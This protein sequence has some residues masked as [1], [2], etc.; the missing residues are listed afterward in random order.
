MQ[1][2][3]SMKG[4]AMLEETMRLRPLLAFDFDGTLAPIVPRPADAHVSVALARRLEQLSRLLPVAVIT[5][6]GVDDV[7]PRLGFEPQFIIGNHGAEDEALT[8]PGGDDALAALR[9]RLRAHDASLRAAGVVVE[10]KRYSVALHYRLA[11][12]R[13]EA[14]GLISAVLDGA[15]EKTRVFGGKCVI[16][17]VPD[18]APDKGEAFASLVAR[19]GTATAVFVGDDVNDEAVFVRS[20]PH[21]LTIR[22]GRDDP[23]SRARY[24]LDGP[25]EVGILLHRML[26]CV[27]PQ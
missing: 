1:N 4:Q 5:G 17:V 2:L 18:D 13:N 16:N 7:A 6:R 27:A 22:V 3:L 19:C 23:G 10:D 11:Y 9:L 8:H 21:W 26:A 25:A 12:D 15:Q 24:F 20:Q 14:L